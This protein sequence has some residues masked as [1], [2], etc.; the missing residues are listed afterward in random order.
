MGRLSYFTGAASLLLGIV[1]KGAA[2]T[3]P[4]PVLDSSG[5]RPAG[6]EKVKVFIDPRSGHLAVFDRYAELP[7]IVELSRFTAPAITVKIV[8]E[9]AG[10]YRYEYIFSNGI[11]AKQ[12]AWNWMFE[13]LVNDIQVGELPTGW[14]VRIP[15]AM[16]RE[17]RYPDGQEPITVRSLWFHA[18]VRDGVNQDM[19]VA[20]G[21]S[22][23]GPVLRSRLKPG[24]L[25]V[26]VAGQSDIAR[27]RGEPDS[28]VIEIV[29][30]V[31]R[32]KYNYRQVITFGPK[33]ATSADRR[34]IAGDFE[35]VL[36]LLI[37]QGTIGP[38]GQFATTFKVLMRDSTSRV[39]PSERFEAARAVATLPIE[40]E[41]LV[42][43][44]LAL[45]VAE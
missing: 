10:L 28:D 13:N 14:S 23:P 5:S 8:L 29:S 40:S 41:M 34:V 45:G 22:I 15:P 30:S 33:F 27:L 6:M 39:L 25:V 1:L 7:A 35:N 42:A 43:A 2:E 11:S 32:S 17:R 21:Q 9:P 38:T 36:E 18:G 44:Y 12:K 20:P 31:T 19:G 4:V 37:K 24:P 26:W 3:P 16:A